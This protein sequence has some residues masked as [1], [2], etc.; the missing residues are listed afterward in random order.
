MR[1][2]YDDYERG[3]E[4]GRRSFLRESKE[5][6]NNPN[7][8]K[9]DDILS[10]V[11][12][13]KEYEDK[14]IYSGEYLK[15]QFDKEGNRLINGEVYLTTTNK[16]LLSVRYKFDYLRLELDAVKDASKFSNKDFMLYLN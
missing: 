11:F 3:Y 7:F 10:S 6:L 1:K 12:D 2:Y 15:I 5:N 8:E 4:D 16:L 13:K 14:I 9:A